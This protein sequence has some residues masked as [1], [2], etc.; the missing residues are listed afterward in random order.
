MTSR[1]R[2]LS[3]VHRLVAAAK[4]SDAEQNR[5]SEVLQRYG[6]E[7]A[8]NQLCAGRKF[9]GLKSDLWLLQLERKRI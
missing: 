5:K 6:L 2:E 4:P 1:R 9:K 8:R 7:H 3:S